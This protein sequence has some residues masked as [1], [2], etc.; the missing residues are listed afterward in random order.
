MKKNIKK[1]PWIK[2]RHKVITRLAASILY[3]YVKFEYGIKIE[4]FKDQGNRPYLVLYNHQTGFDQFFLGMAFRGAI[5]YV[6]TEDIFSNGC[7]S[8]LLTWAVNLIPIKKQTLDMRAIM[9]CIQVAKEGGTIA[10]A[11]E[12]NR[13]Y[14]GKTS[15]YQ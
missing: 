9:N 2:P 1:Q 14:S 5:Y 13:T 6:A 8:R 3:P 11:P 4:R 12:G 10:L 7:I 15:L